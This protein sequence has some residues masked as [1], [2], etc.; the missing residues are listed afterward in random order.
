MPKKNLLIFITLISLVIIGALIFDLMQSSKHKTLQSSIDDSYSVVTVDMDLDTSVVSTKDILSGQDPLLVVV[1]PSKNQSEAPSIYVIR[2][3]T[4]L[5]AL[6]IH[7]N[8]TINQ[9]DPIY[10]TLALA[11]LPAPK[12]AQQLFSAPGK[13]FSRDNPKIRIVPLDTA[14][15]RG[16][17]FDENWD[18]VREQDVK[19]PNFAETIIFALM[20]DNSKRPISEVKVPFSIIRDVQESL[21]LSKKN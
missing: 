21:K 17:L 8:K 16:I 18:W 11:Y 19:H 20:A 13:F 1:Q 6:N 15:I 2:N 4:E 12:T 10:K 5:A 7:Q 3:L 9:F 14:G